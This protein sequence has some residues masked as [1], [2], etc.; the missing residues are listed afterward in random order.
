[1]F[2][3]TPSLPMQILTKSGVEM[4]M[5]GKNFNPYFRDLLG[6]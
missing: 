5:T 1:M 6:D 4:E 3:E 2:R